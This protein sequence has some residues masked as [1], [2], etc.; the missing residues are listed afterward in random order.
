VNARILAQHRFHFC[1]NRIDSLKWP[2]NDHVQVVKLLA[3]HLPGVDKLNDA[4]VL[5]NAP[6]EAQHQGI[7]AD[8]V[9]LARFAPR[10]VAVILRIEQPLRIDAIGAAAEQ[11]LGL[12][13]AAQLV[14]DQQVA[15]RGADANH[16]GR[17]GARE[18]VAGHQGEAPEAAVRET[19]GRE[20]SIAALACRQQAQHAQ[21]TA[22][23]RVGARRPAQPAQDAHDPPNAA[24]SLKERLKMYRHYAR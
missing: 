11:H 10:L 21:Q 17:Q 20:C 22:L 24:E 7:L 15:D 6:D 9:T 1:R 12:V 2:D 3:E 13:G 4:L 23:G 16:L 5:G 18:L 8:A 14:L 19:A